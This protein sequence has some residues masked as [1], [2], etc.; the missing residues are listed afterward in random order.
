MERCW[1]RYGKKWLKPK[2]LAEGLLLF[3]VVGHPVTMHGT[4]EYMKIW[5][6]L[7]DLTTAQGL[8]VFM[9]GTHL[10]KSKWLPTTLCVPQGH[11]LM[12]DSRLQTRREY[13]GSGGIVLAR[14][15][16]MTGL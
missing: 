4:A 3:P 1:E 13:V 8:P 2:L 10:D 7:A 15:Y 6:P 16:D 11:A 9:M 14:I 5:V 12:F